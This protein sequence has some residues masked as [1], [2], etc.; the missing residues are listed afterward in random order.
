MGCPV[1]RLRY[2]YVFTPNF[3]FNEVAECYRQ[4]E[5]IL[6]ERHPLLVGETGRREK[7]DGAGLGRHHRQADGPPLHRVIA[8][9]IPFQ[10]A[11]AAGLPGPV[12]GD[13][14]KSAEE[15]DDVEGAQR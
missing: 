14:Q 11:A 8:A 1:S 12:C 6:D 13:G 5:I 9:E 2:T 3:I 7:G 10:V 4:A 15:D